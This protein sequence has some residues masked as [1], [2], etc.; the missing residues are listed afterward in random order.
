MTAFMDKL[1]TRRCATAQS[2]EG[3]GLDC[4]TLD[5]LPVGHAST[6]LGFDGDDAVSRRLFNLGFAP[7]LEV[8][9]LRRAPL[10]DPLMFRV[11]GCEIV[12]RRREA[13]RILVAS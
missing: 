1:T 5:S 13:R 7:G 3:V 11:D 10:R 8:A 4:R 9:L 12:L 2:L 6:I